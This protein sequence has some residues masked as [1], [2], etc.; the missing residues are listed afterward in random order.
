LLVLEESEPPPPPLPLPG[1]LD[2]W[3]QLLPGTV[4]KYWLTPETPGGAQ[5]A[6]RAPT[7]AASA[8]RHAIK[9]RRSFKLMD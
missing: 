7:G 8:T 9:N 1:P 2:G 6:A 5:L 3:L 4:S